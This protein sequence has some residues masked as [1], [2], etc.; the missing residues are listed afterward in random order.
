MLKGGLQATTIW[1]DRKMPR[2]RGASC[3]F[4]LQCE[5]HSSH[6]QFGIVQWVQQCCFFALPPFANV[7]GPASITAVMANKSAFLI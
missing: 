6:V 2:F 5:Q 1:L 7:T 3:L 4:Y